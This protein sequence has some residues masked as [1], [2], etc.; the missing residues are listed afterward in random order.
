M[1]ARTDV[2]PARIEMRHRECLKSSEDFRAR[3]ARGDPELFGRLIRTHAQYI[4]AAVRRYAP[5]DCDAEE[6]ASETWILVWEKRAQFRGE[7][8]CASFRVWLARLCR[9][10]CARAAREIRKRKTHLSVDDPRNSA[11][12]RLAARTAECAVEAARISDEV[13]DIRLDL[14]MALPKRQRAVVLHRLC[15]GLS[16]RETA[17]LL[18]CAEGTVKAALHSAVATLRKANQASSD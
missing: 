15:E 18:G 14:V 9:T 3:F 6:C 7:H 8:D 2:N 16:T 11:L 13:N 5:S 4:A 12:N 10:V 17:A 1:R